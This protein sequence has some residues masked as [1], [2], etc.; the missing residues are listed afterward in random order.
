[1][2]AQ[3]LFS[4]WKIIFLYVRNIH[5]RVKLWDFK[6]FGR[7][8]TQT[9]LDLGW[10]KWNRTFHF[11]LLCQKHSLLK[12]TKGPE[13]SIFSFLLMGTFQWDIPR[14]CCV[15]ANTAVMSLINRGLLFLIL[16]Y[17]LVF[18]KEIGN[19]CLSKVVQLKVLTFLLFHL[20]SNQHLFFNSWNGTNICCFRALKIFTSDNIEKVQQKRL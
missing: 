12:E 5:F 13:Y 11:K 19:S 17:S 3:K 9:L 14:N 6:S 4:W 18:M 10:A 20:P 16:S 7:S 1:M 2:Y 8:Y 15:K